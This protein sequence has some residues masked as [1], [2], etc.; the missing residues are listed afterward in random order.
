[1]LREMGEAGFA[2]NLVTRSHP[3]PDLDSDNWSAGSRSRSTVKPFSSLCS[4][5]RENKSVVSPGLNQHKETH[6]K[7]LKEGQ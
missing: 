2:Q 5:T 6:Q 1:M 7:I 4:W 3:I